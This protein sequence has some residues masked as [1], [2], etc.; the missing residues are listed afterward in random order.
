MDKTLHE[1]RELMD[2]NPLKKAVMLGKIWGA[3]LSNSEEK[4]RV[5]Y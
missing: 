5:I 1:K 4:E 3:D 2:K